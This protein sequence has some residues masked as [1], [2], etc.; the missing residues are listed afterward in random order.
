MKVECDQIFIL[1]DENALLQNMGL[2]KTTDD[3]IKR[4]FDAEIADYLK[5]QM[6]IVVES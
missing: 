2:A 3:E 5:S 4:V 6:M 1:R